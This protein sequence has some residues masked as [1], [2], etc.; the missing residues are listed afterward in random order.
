MK[1]IC[2]LYGVPA[3]MVGVGD[4]KYN[5]TQTM[6]DEFYK[7]T[8][9]P[10][11]VNAQQKLKQALF[12]DYPNLYVEFDTKNFLK[13]APLDQM[14]FVNFGVKAGVMTPNEGREYLGMSKMEGADELVGDGGKVEPIPGSSPQDT[15]G[16]GGNQT[17][18]MNIGK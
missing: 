15:G 6:L 11:L 2:A 13:G 9:Y 14:N 10:I 18:K 16:G 5:N 12:N 8:M 17:R 3:A 1:R 7:S 4:S